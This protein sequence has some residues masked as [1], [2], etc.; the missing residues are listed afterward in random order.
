MGELSTSGV[1][2]VMLDRLGE[3]VARATSVVRYLPE[4]PFP[5]HRHP[6][7]EEILVLAGQFSEGIMI[8]LL[9]GIYETRRAPLI[10]RIAKMAPNF[11]QTGT[12]ELRCSA[13]RSDKYP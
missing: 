12:N 6:G 9:D 11:C 4:T 1:D 3:E 10:N 2:R 8:I 5:F 7:G 13:A